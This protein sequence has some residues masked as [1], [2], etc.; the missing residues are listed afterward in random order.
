MFSPPASEWLRTSQRG[1][2][3]FIRNWSPC[4]AFSNLSYEI[5]DHVDVRAIN[6]QTHRDIHINASFSQMEV[7]FIINIGILGSFIPTFS[8]TVLPFRARWIQQKILWQYL[9]GPYFV[10]KKHF[11]IK[12]TLK[13]TEIWGTYQYYSRH[14]RFTFLRLILLLCKVCLGKRQLFGFV[15][16]FEIAAPTLKKS[17]KEYHSKSNT[18]L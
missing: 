17:A 12:N 1:L 10:L 8:T 5:A 7:T 16:F 2:A 15:V 13:P 14:L 6:A 3:K 11:F 9:E 18:L 4:T